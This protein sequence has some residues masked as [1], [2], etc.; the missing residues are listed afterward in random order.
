MIRNGNRNRLRRSRLFLPGN[1]PKILQDGGVFEAD[2][3]ILDLEDAV[4]IDSKDEARVL[5]KWA[6]RE[7]DFGGSEVL[8]RV[9]SPETEFFHQDMEVISEA[10]DGIVLPKAESRTDVEKVA[11]LL[12]KI[13]EEKAIEKEIVIIPTIESALGV[14][15]AYD[16]ARAPRVAALAFGAED[17]TKDIGAERTPDGRELWYA[18]SA[19]VTAAKA[20][21]VQALDTVYP[22]V[23]DDEGLRKE[24]E[25]SR[26]MGFDGKSAIHPNQIGI[27]HDVFTPST[28]EIRKA[29]E[30]MQA[31]TDAEE[32]KSG[33]IALNGRMIDRPVV[34][35]AKRV[36]RLAEAAGVD[37]EHLPEE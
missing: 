26:R 18:R 6:L 34:E 16:I 9:N 12:D 4:S 21:G 32:K 29:L 19:I 27:I 14:L 13:E 8:I 11:A 28:E 15:N 24:T 2:S 5:V 22:N 37:M 7:V 30:V 10:V 3:V 35:R 17:F 33:V 23:R 36:I 1:N 25:A 31:I 20:A